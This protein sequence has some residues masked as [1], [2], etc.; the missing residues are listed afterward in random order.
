MVIE[1][2]P[3]YVSTALRMMYNSRVGR[4]LAKSA[5]GLL[6]RMS[7][8]QGRKYDSE[9]SKKEIPKFVSLHNLD[10]S[11]LTKDLDDFKTFNEFFAREIKPESR[12][13]ACP[14]DDKVVVSPA[15]CRC[16]VCLRTFL[17]PNNCPRTLL[18]HYSPKIFEH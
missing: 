6:A 17:C 9:D 3:T 14:D 13:V 16:M 5:T 18:A 12:P 8:K 15:D 1:E 7:A 11:I 2:I 4:M 10:T